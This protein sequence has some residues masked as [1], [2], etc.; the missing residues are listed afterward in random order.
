[1]I[2]AAAVQTQPIFGDVAA[3]LERTRQLVLSER[4]LLYVLPELFSTGYL[5]R[6]REET[7][8][9]AEDYPSGDACRFLAELSGTTGAVVVGGF[10]EKA[11]GGRL[12]NSAA[13]ADR[14]KLL[15]CYRKIHLFDREKACF[16]AGECAPHVVATSIGR[17]GM[18]IC[19]DWIFP[20]TAR[21]LA[22]AGAQILAHATNLVMPYCQNAMPTRC[23]ENRVFA[24]TANRIGEEARD[25]TRLAFTGWSQI[26]GHTGE[27]LAQAS[28]ESEEVICAEFDP[29]LA[30]DKQVTPENHLFRDRRPGLYGEMWR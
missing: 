18:M 24:V 14:G 22:L 26:T 3:N 28:A 16:D 17:V 15:S 11:S 23:I 25:G 13:L 19:F 21:C 27:R 10:A 9:L 7:A 5:F 29:A 8:S 20:E 4:A 30:D 6:D 12:Y 2:R 1:M